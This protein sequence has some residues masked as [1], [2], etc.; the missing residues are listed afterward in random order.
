MDR[1]YK[2]EVIVLKRIN[3]AE[4]D[5]IITVFSKHYGKIKCLAKGVRKLTSR[6]GGNLELFNLVTMFLAKG[7]NLDI[8]TEAQVIDSFSGFRQ[9]LKKT[10]IAFQLSEL[11][12]RFTRENQANWQVFEVLKNS[13]NKLSQA[14]VDLEK[15]VIDFKIKILEHTGFGLPTEINSK[16]LDSHI[17]KIIEKKVKSFYD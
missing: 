17:E 8:V 1:T 5:K 2:T 13:F 11:V 4:A 9:D 6:K 15:L 16:S 14:E 12:D 7:K 10:A 3:Y